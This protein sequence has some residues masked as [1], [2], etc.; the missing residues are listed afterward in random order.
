MRADQRRIAI[1]TEVISQ[2]SQKSAERYAQALWEEERRQHFLRASESVRKRKIPARPHPFDLRQGRKARPSKALLETLYTETPLNCRDIA[3]FYEVSNTTVLTWLRQCEIPIVR[4]GK[5]HL[6]RKQNFKRR[7]IIDGIP[8]KL[9][10]GPSHKKPTWVPFSDFYRNYSPN[11]SADGIAGVCKAC[12]G[13]RGGHPRQVPYKK[14]EF[15][16]IELV[17]R[18]GVNETCRRVPISTTTLWKYRN[19]KSK[20]VHRG[21]AE[22]ILQALSEVRSNGEI[23][24]AHSIHHGASARGKEEKIPSRARDFYRKQTDIETEKRRA[25]R[26]KALV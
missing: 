16:I 12:E 4:E 19:K 25:L 7:K 15:A 18:L 24:H 11:H 22:K 10:N 2:G 14:V 5:V 1:A 26:L 20:Q 13:V 3:L 9:C 6:I 8:H 17:N 23:R 21:T